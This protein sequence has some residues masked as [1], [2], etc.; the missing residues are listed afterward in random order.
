MAYDLEEQEQLANM[1]AWWGKYGNMLT[2]LLI[3]VL[4][5]Y[6]AWTGWN[7]YQRSQAMQAAQLYEEVQGALASNDN[8]K[9]QRAATDMQQKFSGTAYAQMSAMAAAKSAVTA[10]DLSAAKTQLQWVVEHG[11]EAYVA[12]A[13]IRLAGILLD[14][15]SYDAALA[16]LAGSFPAQFSSV[17]ADRKGDVLI[18][19]SK[20]EEARSAYQEALAKSDEKDPARQLIQIKLDAIGGGIKAAA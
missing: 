18:A 9:V 13:K 1:K 17:V 11:D 5:S 7:Y 19:Q 8:V 20:T 12:I 10:N 14:E 3:V 16:M 6:A 2:W 4:G 15:K